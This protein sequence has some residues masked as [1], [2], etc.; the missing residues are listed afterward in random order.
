[1]QLARKLIENNAEF[2]PSSFLWTLSSTFIEHDP[3]N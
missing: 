1:M 2:V 3:Q